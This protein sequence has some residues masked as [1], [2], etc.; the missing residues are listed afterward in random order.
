M[1]ECWRFTDSGDQPCWLP[2]RS[3]GASWKPL[4]RDTGT[5]GRYGEYTSCSFPR[6]SVGT[7]A[8]PARR[9]ERMAK[10]HPFGKCIRAPIW[11]Y[12]RRAMR[13]RAPTQERGSQLETAISGHGNPPAAAPAGLVDTRLAP[14]LVPTL[15]RGNACGVCMTAGKDGKVTSIREM[16]PCADMGI[17]AVCNSVGLPRKSVG[18]SWDC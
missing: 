5:P 9:Q 2:R 8:E 14:L 1:R 4:S 15:Q 16:H 17:S 6:S 12:Q 18:A 3:V 7:H 13:C 11:E 10:L